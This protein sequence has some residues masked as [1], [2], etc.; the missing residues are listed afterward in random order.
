MTAADDLHYNKMLDR[1]ERNAYYRNLHVAALDAPEFPRPRRHK[2]VADIDIVTAA[3]LYRSGVSA[4]EIGRQIGVGKTAVVH[5]L[6][7]AGVEIRNTSQA[8]QARYAASTGR[9]HDTIRPCAGCGRSTRPSNLTL[10]DYPGTVQRV[11]DGKCSR[12]IGNDE[13]GGVAARP[14][15]IVIDVE[16]AARMYAD[17]ESTTAIGLVMGVSKSK[18]RL[19]LIRAGVTMRTAGE[20]RRAREMARVAA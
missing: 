9:Q 6:A 19:D 1:I 5:A 15:S 3:R 4:S 7:R 14:V 12:C 11:T 16:L 8:S 2:P 20:A 18:V 13:R 10:T 17:M